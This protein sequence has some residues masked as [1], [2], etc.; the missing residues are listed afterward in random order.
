MSAFD[1][2]F[3]P[4]EGWRTEAESGGSQ[5]VKSVRFA[6]A[7]DDVGIQDG[8]VAYTPAAGETLLLYSSS[9]VVTENFDNGALSCF[10]QGDN[11]TDFIIYGSG[12]PSLSTV[13]GSHLRPVSL[14]SLL[15]N[16][17]GGENVYF[18]DAT[19]LLVA[20]NDGNYDP[21]PLGPSGASSGAA[22]FVFL[23]VAAP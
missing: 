6:F 21:G 23:I 12:N 18:T 11:P 15:F 17:T 1:R 14:A 10:Q 22:E 16:G 13:E 5:A 8:L 20:Y 3:R 19:P 7:F 4:G 9:L 2:I